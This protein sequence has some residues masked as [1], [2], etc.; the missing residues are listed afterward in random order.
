MKKIGIFKMSIVFIAGLMLAGVS[1]EASWWSTVP[2]TYGSASLE[3]SNGQKIVTGRYNILHSVYQ[4]NGAIMYTFSTDGLTWSTPIALACGTPSKYPAIAADSSGKLAVVWHD[5]NTDSISYV[6]HNGTSWSMPMQIVASG[7]EPSIVARGTTVYLAWTTQNAVRYASF[8]TLT[9]AL[10]TG[11][12][13]GSTTCNATHFRLPSI[14]L[15]EN[16][17]NPPIPVVGFLYD[18]D[19]QTTVG[20]CNNPT[21]SVGPKV[22]KRDN[23]MGVWNLAW[24]NLRTSLTTG[25]TVESISLA[26]AS[27]YSS[28]DLYVG[29]SDVQNGGARTD[30]GH[31]RGA[32]WST[33]ANLDN[34]R[35][36]IHVRANES[37]ASPVGTF[38]LA[39]AYDGGYD[40]NYRDGVWAGTGA[41]SWTSATTYTTGPP[42][43]RPHAAWWKRCSAGTQTDVRVLAEEDLAV[44][45]P[46]SGT[47]LGVESEQVTPCPTVVIGPIPY[48]PCKAILLATAV[49]SGPGVGGPIVVVDVTEA[50]VL[51]SATDRGATVVTASGDT[52]NISWRTGRVAWSSDSVVALT[53]TTEADVTF[54]SSKA[55]FTVERQGAVGGFDRTPNVCPAR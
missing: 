21:T 27:R 41:L 11:E 3:F 46:C 44:C 32:T 2:Y 8:P 22:Y 48:Y 38:R 53:G 24:S 5:V 35:H 16:P 47:S 39:M 6:F 10:V 17:C 13:I 31:G 26:V 23:V 30:L 19:E 51:K 33:A 29:Y 40:A 1:A 45:I 42:A 25:S 28:G 9:P 37:S 4:D 54:T 55:K 36:H 43:A 52:I 14:A 7:T 12:V 20:V 18:S 34:L 49:L 50:G 15:I